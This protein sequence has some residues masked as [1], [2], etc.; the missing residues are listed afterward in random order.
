M[1][2]TTTKRTKEIVSFETQYQPS[3][4]TLKEG[5]MKKWNLIQ[6]YFA[7]FFKEPAI[8]SYKKGKS[9]KNMLIRA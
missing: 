7:K 5:S 1:L 9:I 2:K 8:I 6:F 3:V 4:S